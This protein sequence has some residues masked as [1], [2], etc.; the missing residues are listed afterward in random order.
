[1]AENGEKSSSPLSPFLLLLFLFF[2]FF[3]FFFFF[4]SNNKK[5]FQSWKLKSFV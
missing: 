3:Y 1:M 4:A 2:F 5:D